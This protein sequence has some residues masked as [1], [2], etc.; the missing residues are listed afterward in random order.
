MRCSACGTALKRFMEEG[1][2]SE[3]AKLPA[4][5]FC[6]NYACEQLASPRPLAAMTPAI[7]LSMAI[8][9]LDDY[10][11][12]G[13]NVVDRVAAAIQAAASMVVDH[14]AEEALCARCQLAVLRRDGTCYVCDGPKR[15]D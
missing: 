9:A 7:A 4:R 10:E 13:L 15:S 14:A 6:P 8:S 1:P 12:T 5:Y 11:R 3:I 2:E